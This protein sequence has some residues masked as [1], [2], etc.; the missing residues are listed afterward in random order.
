MA[1]DIGTFTKDK[2]QIDFT[3]ADGKRHKMPINKIDVPTAFSLFQKCPLT[4]G[5]IKEELLEKLSEEE[6]INR[7]KMEHEF[8]LD[9]VKPYF[10]EFFREKIK[11]IPYVTFIK[12]IDYLVTGTEEEQTLQEMLE[13]IHRKEFGKKKPKA[14]GRKKAASMRK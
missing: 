9:L 8:M 3:D 4:Y 2:L 6:R 13:E 14:K 5:Q 12:M 11:H 1:F 10:P 7:R